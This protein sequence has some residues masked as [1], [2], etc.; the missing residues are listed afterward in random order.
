[1]LDIFRTNPDRFDAVITDQT[2]PKITGEHLAT[3]LLTIRP[4]IPIIVCTGFSYSLT[5]EKA[6]AIGIRRLLNKPLLI[7]DLAAALE[8]VLN[9]K[10]AASRS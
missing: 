4:S 5:P 3:E 7:Q 6:Q 9:N 8:E 10:V 2:M 1:A